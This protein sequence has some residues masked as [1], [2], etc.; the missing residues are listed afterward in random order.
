MVSILEHVREQLEFAA[1][2][3]LETCSTLG[4]MVQ[5]YAHPYKTEQKRAGD[6]II[7]NRN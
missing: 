7:K 4:R 5:K 6:V 1:S 3:R 2:V